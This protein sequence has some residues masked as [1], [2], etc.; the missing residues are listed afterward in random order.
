MHVVYTGERVKLRPFR[1]AEELWQFSSRQFITLSDFWG[2]DWHRAIRSQKRFGNSISHDAAER[3][4]IER[5]DSGEAIGWVSAV[6]GTYQLAASVGTEILRE[7]WHQGFGREAKLL[8]ICHL[9]ENFAIESVWADTLAVHT[10]ARAGLE[11]IGF[12]HVGT[13]PCAFRHRGT[14]VA[15]VKYQIMREDW[16]K[17]P[18]RE[19]VVRGQ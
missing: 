19:T 2:D 14:R 11:A 6:L 15:R 13:I 3:F 10:R 18:I 8:S 1:D 16:E 9:F 17:L 12:R 4:C 7:H 5:L